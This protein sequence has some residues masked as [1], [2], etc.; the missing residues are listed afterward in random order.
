MYSRDVILTPLLTNEITISELLVL[1]NPRRYFSKYMYFSLFVYISIVLIY[2]VHVSDVYY[3][4]LRMGYTRRTK[5][6]QKE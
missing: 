4:I 6:L 3:R 2:S 1:L 5:G